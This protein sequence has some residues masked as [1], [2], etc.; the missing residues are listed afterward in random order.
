[1][2]GVEV[3][4]TYS[5][6]SCQERSRFE[7]SCTFLGEPSATAFQRHEASGA[8]IEARLF[9]TCQVKYLLCQIMVLW[10]R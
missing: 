3:T 5:S 9:F 6:S 1:M 7:S 2:V 10:N 8:G 4:A